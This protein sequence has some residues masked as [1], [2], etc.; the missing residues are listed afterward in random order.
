MKIMYILEFT[1]DKLYIELFVG[2]E[3]IYL[4]DHKDLVFMCTFLLNIIYM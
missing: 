3:F 4:S 1:W 2:F